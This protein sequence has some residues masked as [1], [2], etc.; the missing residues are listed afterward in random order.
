MAANRICVS[1]HCDCGYRN[2][3]FDYFNC[4]SIFEIFEMIFIE[5]R[6]ETKKKTTLARWFALSI[7]V[8]AQTFAWEKSLI[9]LPM[10]FYA[11]S[12]RKIIPNEMNVN[13]YD[14]STVYVNRNE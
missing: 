9:K 8:R 1:M 6:N 3:Q 4:V 5:K 11:I 2:R 10:L 7:R 14:V 12:L 13:C